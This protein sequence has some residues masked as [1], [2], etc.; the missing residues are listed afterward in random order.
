MKSK[1]EDLKNL[2][3][4]DKLLNLPEIKELISHY[5]VDL[6]KH[7]IRN[8]IDQIRKDA[9]KSKKIPAVPEIILQIKKGIKQFNQKSLKNVINATG[10]IVHTN[11][12]RA[13]FSDDI[14]NEAAEILRGYNNLEFDL[15]KGERGSRNTHLTKLLKFLTGA[16]DILVVNNN[17]AAI[18]LILRT[19]AKEKEVIV[20]RGELIEI[21]GS[22]RLPDI[23]AASDCK[24]IEVGTTNKTRI[25]DY[26]DHITNNTALFFK[27]HQSNY[28]IQGFTEEASLTELVTLGKQYSIP[29]VYDMGSGLL[30]KTSIDLFRYEPDVKQTLATGIDL[31]CFSGDKLL[32]GAQAGI[33]AGKKELVAT[34]KK[35]PMVR[36]LRVG[37]ATLALMEAALSY[38]LDD[39][40]LVKKNMLFSMMTT[41]P[42]ELKS[43][44]EKLHKILSD[45]QIPSIV[46]ES[47]GQCGGGALPGKEIDSFAIRIDRPFESNKQ[48][49]VFSEKLYA[50]LMTHESPVVAI[51]RKGDVYFDMLTVPEEQFAKLA[52]TVKD[53]YFEI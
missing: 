14:M 18:M 51:L 40:E 44:A 47:K 35:D 29:V 31:V 48:K 6:V 26:K 36:A 24:M 45:Y 28:I 1:M 5:Q 49:S 53:V 8:I 38:Y 52:T 42:E 4:I 22:F 17:A 19:F 23:M 37:K 32:G 3:G 7:V 12:G 16:E 10:V 9:L 34:L 46:V 21:G 39:K 2:P 25:N 27:A 11:L 20:S 33:I 13:P 50:G 15:E 30:R 43:K 41:K